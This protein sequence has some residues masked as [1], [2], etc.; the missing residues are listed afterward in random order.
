M[1]PAGTDPTARAR[2][3]YR[4]AQRYA[5]KGG[6]GQAIAH[7]GRAL[8]YSRFGAPPEK[9]SEN[10]KN[11]APDSRLESYEEMLQTY[12]DFQVR[13]KTGSIAVFPNSSRTNDEAVYDDLR[14]QQGS[15]LIAGHLKIH[16]LE[17]DVDVRPG[18]GEKE[19]PVPR[20]GT[21]E[22]VAVNLL[23]YLLWKFHY[24]LAQPDGRSRED[25][26]LG[27]YTDEALL[28]CKY[29]IRD[30][31]FR[32][33]IRDKDSPAREAAETAALY[34]MLQRRY[35]ELRIK[36][37]PYDTKKE[38]GYKYTVIGFVDELKPRIKTQIVKS[39]TLK[40]TD[41]VFYELVFCTNGFIYWYQDQD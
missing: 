9:I 33:A 10:H 24:L 40:V 7:F 32:E 11:G 23:G 28:K 18:L 29:K 13:T 36:P 12:K 21:T 27:R 2:A 6:I 34:E 25:I 4:W 31:P 16:A 1:A 22:P 14:T 35:P 39:V 8:E 41:D 17:I 26:Y 37:P 19:Y 20:N 3:H 5:D 30:D 15:T 38:D